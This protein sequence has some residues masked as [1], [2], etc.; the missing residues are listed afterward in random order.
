MPRRCDE[1]RTSPHCDMPPEGAGIADAAAIDASA[2]A[3]DL[4]RYRLGADLAALE[5]RVVTRR[6]HHRHSSW[7]RATRLHWSA[8]CS[9]MTGRSEVSVRTVQFS[10]SD[11]EQLAHVCSACRPRRAGELTEV[12]GAASMLELVDRYL[13]PGD[14]YRP[15][16]NFSQGAGAPT[17]GDRDALHEARRDA[18]AARR[19][20][21]R[22]AH[23]NPDASDVLAAVE[24][25]RPLPVSSELLDRLVVAA[26]Q[27]QDSYQAQLLTSLGAG[28][29]ADAVADLPCGKAARRTRLR[30]HAL[31]CWPQVSAAQLAALPPESEPQGDEAP[32]SASPYQ[33]LQRHWITQVVVAAEDLHDSLTRLRRRGGHDRP[34]LLLSSLD[35]NDVEEASRWQI[36]TGL[37]VVVDHAANQRYDLRLY[38]LPAAAADLVEEMVGGLVAHVGPDDGDR[39]EAGHLALTIG[40]S[41][42]AQDSGPDGGA[43]ESGSSALADAVAVALAA[44][45]GGPA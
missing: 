8:T 4:I 10:T 25:R 36:P 17:G 33:Q 32:A 28:R 30:E 6:L 27:S 7:R 2:V 23:L 24:G 39:R 42:A 3:A 22:L 20:A 44:W 12:V 29:V 31:A 18:A 45:D 40:V 13:R 21:R 9:Q 15:D 5:D 11:T 16:Q 37:A 19:H 26:W 43:P 34:A 38:S 35:L 1:T 14:H 41:A